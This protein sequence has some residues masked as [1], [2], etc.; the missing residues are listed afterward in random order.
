MAKRGELPV[1]TDFWVDVKSYFNTFYR[2]FLMTTRIWF[3]HRHG[4]WRS[5]RGLT[6][7]WF[8]YCCCFPMKGLI[9]VL[10]YISFLS[11]DLK[12]HSKFLFNF[13]ASFLKNIYSKSL[14]TLQFLIEL[15]LFFPVEIW[16]CTVDDNPFKRCLICKYFPLRIICFFL[17]LF[18]WNSA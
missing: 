14:N 15:F 9:L 7:M 16:N 5:R 2:F 18:Y 12:H 11:S 17:F 10:T 13:W 6:K 3:K 8:I 4:G 1:D